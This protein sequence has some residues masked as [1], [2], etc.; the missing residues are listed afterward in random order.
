MRKLTEQ[1]LIDMVE[2]ET[3]ID[4]YEVVDVRPK[5]NC[6][7]SGIILGENKHGQWVTWEFRLEKNG[8]PKVQWGH[9]SN[10]K[11]V[12]KNDYHCRD[13]WTHYPMPKSAV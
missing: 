10:D 12:A 1:D 3:V 2:G 7:Y 11:E 8:M 9:Y 5:D 4:G 6:E 13:K